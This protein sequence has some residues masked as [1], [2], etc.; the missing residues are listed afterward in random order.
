MKAT[1]VGLCFISAA[2]LYGEN[3]L[4]NGNFEQLSANGVP[5]SWNLSVPK[6]KAS[7]KMESR[8]MDGV[9]GKTILFRWGAGASGGSL[10]QEIQVRPEEKYILSMKVRSKAYSSDPKNEY[11]IDAG[12]FFRDAS[13][14]WIG[15]KNLGRY[16]CRSL[17]WKAANCQPNEKMKQYRFEITT[18]PNAVKIGIRL[19]F[20]GS[21]I[22][23]EW[24][25]IS[26]T[27]PEKT[28]DQKLNEFS[29]PE[30]VPSDGK[31]VSA[32]GVTLTPDWSGRDTFQVSGAV[33]WRMTLNALWGFRPA[34]SNGAW[35]F[36]KVPGEIRSP[37]GWN[38][39]Y[40][41]TE[42]YDLRKTS[43]C[44]LF[45][46]VDIPK[47]KTGDFFLFF[48]G[49]E[50][51]AVRVFWNGKNIG[52]ID[53]D[54]G[55]EV[56][57]PG[58]L[59]RYDG[60]NALAL[61][62]LAR[63][64]DAR[65]AHLYWLGK[66]VRKYE[67]LSVAWT[68]ARLFDV[69]LLMRGKTPLFERLRINPD[70]DSKELKASFVPK[71]SVLPAGVD[72]RICDLQGKTLLEKKGIPV[73][74]NGNSVSLAIPWEKPVEWT[75]D[76]PNLLT[77]TLAGFDR[78]GSLLD[79]S[80]PERFGF[81]S[82]K[83]VGKKLYLNGKE[84]RLRPRQSMT[85]GPLW[86]NDYL[87]RGFSFYK[88]MG[89][90]LMHLGVH[91]GF[92]L[93][94]GGACMS[95]AARLL[96]EI[97]MTTVIF[98]NLARISGGQF[99]SKDHEDVSPELFHFINET[100]IDRLYNHPSIIAYSGFG[101]SP[102]I[103][104]TVSFNTHPAHFGITPLNSEEKII[105]LEKKKVIGAEL[106]QRLTASL[107]FIN[108]MKKLDASRLFLS[109]YDAG[110]GDGW[111]TFTYFNWTAP[112]ETEEF[113]HNYMMRG[114]IPVGSWEHGL[115]YSMSFISHAVPGGDNEPWI[116]E[117][118]AGWIGERAYSR[119][120]AEYRKLAGS[121]Y[122][123]NSGSF[124][125][126]RKGFSG[127][128]ANGFVYRSPIAHEIWAF[129]NTRLY[130]SWR[131]AGVNMGIEPFGPDYNFADREHLFRNNGKII[132]SPAVNLKTPGI[133]A[134]RYQVVFQWPNSAT[135]DRSTAPSGKKPE[136]LTAFGEALYANNR[137]F[138]G[139][140]GG[141]PS[142]F[143]EK[144]HTFFP[145]EKAEKQIVIVYD[146]FRPLNGSVKGTVSVGG[147]KVGKIEIPFAFA[148]AGT[149]F[150]PFAFSASQEGKGIIKVDFL[151]A[152]GEKIAEDSFEFSIIQKTTPHKKG[153]VLY[154][155]QGT[156]GEAVSFAEKKVAGPDFQGAEI[157][158]IAPE[159][160]NSAVIKSV[161][162]G[163]PILIL[164]QKAKMLE[165]M[166]FR[167]Y[168]IRERCFWSRMF[169]SDL[170]HDWRAGGPLAPENYRPERRAYF[171]ATSSSG[172]VAHTVIEV[173]TAGNFTPLIYGGFDLAMTALLK[174]ELS[175]HP[176]IFSQLEFAKNAESDPAAGKILNTVLDILRQ[177]RKLP[178]S[179]AVAGDAALLAELGA[180]DVSSAYPLSGVVLVTEVKDTAALKNF[181]DKGGKAVLLPQKDDVYKALNIS[182][183][184]ENSHCGQADVTGL[185][186]GNFHYRKTIPLVTFDGKIIRKRNN[187]ILI[188]FDPRA[189]DVKNE[190]VL[191]LSR[192]RQ[193]RALAQ[194]LTN[195]GMRLP[196]P[197]ET[198][199]ARMQT[200][201]RPVSLFQRKISAR[202]RKTKQGE[203]S[204]VKPEYD[205]SGWKT[206]EIE[207]QETGMIDVQFRFHFKLT[208]KE[209]V[210]SFE[211][212]NLGTFDDYDE[213]WLNGVRLG[214]ITPENSNPDTAWRI[215]RRYRIPEKLLK[216]GKN[217]LVVHCWNRNGKTKGWNTRARGPFELH[218]RNSMPSLYTGPYSA[219]NKDDPYL[220][221]PW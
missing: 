105:A 56:R 134:D 23:S 137:E 81:R 138:L 94:E 9:A 93:M 180:P 64:S 37:G 49:M 74:R 160:L 192:R 177:Q 218:Y 150:L 71:G 187:L 163:I 143:M 166:G 107:R 176:V 171:C 51:A 217:T 175:G 120:T 122:D 31:S 113:M 54:R 39:L 21:E 110:A 89:F 67:Q 104:H 221:R 133:K 155:P 148:S 18:P 87:K 75:P 80:L 78:D 131:A 42:K 41:N 52:G 3:L 114:V 112:Q 55:G 183:K 66:R 68:P 161:P 103:D 127:H 73:K 43:A 4:K 188:G 205:D 204:F 152:A 129:F 207:K 19:N 149:K 14:K 173:P 77:L 208:G 119:E 116:T 106:K 102:T 48:E 128:A 33:R 216:K 5:V 170:L 190:P 210:D 8:K 145:G 117:Y 146:G 156:A 59:I 12:V 124:L 203:P 197:S 10:A 91:S 184:R 46:T 92:M 200:D 140:I 165:Q 215:Q 167:T 6:D 220:C 199:I 61:L 212:L 86:D 101:T 79:E 50:N 141:K 25:E 70:W 132:A 99:F 144:S 20:H 219:A 40:G 169:A 85:Y 189:L 58:N 162:A 16:A 2:L 98:T 115:P 34:E 72:A 118:A 153:V 158:M 44:W 95:Q 202:I 65:F 186:A 47:E 193:M 151:N 26:L 30:K 201:R 69:E 96:D 130:R 35:A 63:K 100:V 24:A 83:R 53:F 62:V 32:S 123:R 15:Y 76:T 196:G 11:N 111:G 88:D 45:R 60:K 147:E 191:V 194:V 136:H 108:T 126:R 38:M 84:L 185:N 182:F 27:Q 214:G 109:H 125:T 178:Y 22:E 164:S 174:T 139:F 154:D 198:M 135:L 211:I 179:P 159:S 17:K 121:S 142:N 168:P 28:V 57:I 29:Y 195:A 36:L 157:V 209:S 181:L 7:L 172:I 213:T 1:S 82:V 97:G 13:G 90:N 206:F